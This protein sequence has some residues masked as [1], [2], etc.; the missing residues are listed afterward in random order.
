MKMDEAKAL[1]G[2][3]SR[4]RLTS[5]RLMEFRELMASLRWPGS[6]SIQSSKGRRPKGAKA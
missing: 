1:S 4:D 3:T 2:T 5:R 6:R